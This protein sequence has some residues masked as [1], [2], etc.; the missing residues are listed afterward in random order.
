MFLIISKSV[1]ALGIK[2]VSLFS[3]TFV[4]NILLS[5][6]Y[7]T[8]YTRKL[9]KYMQVYMWNVCYCCLILSRIGKDWQILVKLHN[10]K[11]QENRLAILNCCMQT[12]RWS[13]MAQLLGTFF[14]TFHCGHTKSC[15]DVRL[16]IWKKKCGKLCQLL[17]IWSC[18]ML[19]NPDVG[20]SAVGQEPDCEQVK[21]VWYY[22]MLNFVRIFLQTY[23][24]IFLS[25]LSLS[26]LL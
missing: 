20:V 10:N 3:I 2:C 5:K 7:L 15:Y 12:N 26:S 4:W 18:N 13:V 11:F 22:F 8:S 24:F 25:L 6:K 14:A 19:Q 1:S 23:N 16:N 21:Y 9:L 17:K